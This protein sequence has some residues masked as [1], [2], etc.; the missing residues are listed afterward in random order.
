M[1]TE[2]DIQQAMVELQEAC[3]RTFQDIAGSLRPVAESIASLNETFEQMM[4]SRMR[5]E[6]P[7]EFNIEDFNEVSAAV[8]R[9]QFRNRYL[10]GPL[11]GGRAMK[12]EAE[13]RIYLEKP[14]QITRL[15]L[16]FGEDPSE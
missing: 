8:Y 11:P 16:L 3:A 15:E 10:R 4:S 1:P 12:Y 7:S 13:T 9:E 2:E 14:V 6:I 5:I